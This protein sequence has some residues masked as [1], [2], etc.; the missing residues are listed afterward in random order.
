MEGQSAFGRHGFLCFLSQA[1][2]YCISL[3]WWLM[4]LRCIWIKEDMWLLYITLVWTDVL[5]FMCIGSEIEIWKLC[6]SVLWDTWINNFASLPSR[7]GESSEFFMLF[8]TLISCTVRM[9]GE[10]GEKNMLLAGRTGLIDIVRHLEIGSTWVVIC[11]RV[12]CC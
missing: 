6:S 8:Q 2:G 5:Q 7:L 3:W 9:W 4:D 1:R 12:V 10:R 11:S